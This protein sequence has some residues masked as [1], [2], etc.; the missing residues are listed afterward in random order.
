MTFIPVSSA[1]SKAEQWGPLFS[2]FLSPPIFH[3]PLSSGGRRWLAKGVKRCLAQLPQ[4]SPVSQKVAC[5]DQATVMT[6]LRVR[7]V[8]SEGAGS[9]G[10]LYLP[11]SSS[12]RQQPHAFFVKQQRGCQSGVRRDWRLLARLHRLKPL[13][14]RLHNSCMA[15]PCISTLFASTGCQPQ[16]LQSSVD[17]IWLRVW[18]CGFW[19]QMWFVKAI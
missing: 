17:S 7:P 5:R 9:L 19:L 3:C 4:H 18:I 14:F 11:G 12:A 15:L 2:P 16:T 6:L 1:A 8:S 10:D 13:G